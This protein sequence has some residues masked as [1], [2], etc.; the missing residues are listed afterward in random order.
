MAG[1]SLDL[2]AAQAERGRLGEL[3]GTVPF[4]GERGVA[5]AEQVG[6]GHQARL[7][8]DLSTLTPARLVTATDDF[9]VRTGYP[10]LLNPGDANRW[11]IDAG[12][13]VREPAA[14][15][16][17][18]FTHLVSAQGV[19]L[20]ECSGN[21][22]RR[23][24]GLLSA[25]RWDGI[26]LAQLFETLPI[27]RTATRVVIGGFD[28]RQAGL[29]P[30]SLGASWIFTFDQLANAG[31][32]L[33]TRMNGAPLPLDHGFPVRLIAPG[34]YGCANAK[35]VD[36]I[37]FVDD[38][39]VAT[40]QMREFAGRTHQQDTPS[41]ARDF[42]PATMDLAAMPVRVEK[43]RIGGRLGYRIVGIAWGGDRRIDRL[44]IRLGMG[45]PATPIRDLTRETYKTWT[46]WTHTW[47]PPAPGA[48]AIRLET[49][50]PSIRTRRLDRGYYTR[51]V[52]IDEV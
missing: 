31:A 49:D 13:L 16:L 43:R 2:L 40:R 34:W 25:T 1:L 50:D 23:G 30:A 9:F 28:D 44:Q 22:A 39:A 20:L 19:H 45:A 10:D 41:L 7:A 48:Y 37:T 46:L 4:V 29:V 36:A 6:T 5:V 15:R 12:G 8:L 35:W 42:A 11:T 32:F 17:R 51:T 24:F 18:D 3:L 33:A 26:P 38:D 47:Q 14:R 27:E 21:G 52:E